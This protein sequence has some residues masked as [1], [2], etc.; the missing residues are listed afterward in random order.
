MSTAAKKPWARVA[1]R[2][3]EPPPAR[4]AREAHKPRP[5]RTV[6]APEASPRVRSTRPGTV[7]P[8][9]EILAPVFRAADW[10]AFGVTGLVMLAAYLW[11]LAPEVTL[12]D[13]GELAV[14]AQYA[15]VPHAPGYPIWTLYG[16]LFTKLLPFS[17]I[18]WRV[19]VSSAVA[20]ALACAWIALIV[21]RGSRLL[22]DSLPTVSDLV[23]A[24]RQHLG[25][26]S[27]CVAGALLGFSGFVWSQAVIVEVYTLSLLSLTALLACLFRWTCIPTQRR[28]LYLAWFLFGICLNNHQS[29]MVIALAMEVCVSMADRRLGRDL[30]LGN[31]LCYVIGLIAKAGGA[32]PFLNHNAP[33]LACYHAIGLASIGAA[34]WLTIRT[35]AL[36]RQFHLALACAGAFLVGAA[37][38]LWM[39]LGSMANPPMNWA[40]P[41]TVSGFFHAL[42]RG[43]YEPVHPAQDL[44]RYVE[45]LWHLGQGVIEEFHVFYLLAGLL[46]ILLL[47]RFAARERGWLIAGL[48]FYFVLGPGLLVLI[49]PGTERAQQELV[50][51]FFAA[52]HVPVAIAI[53]FGLALGLALLRTSYATVRQWALVGAGAAVVWGLASTAW[54]WHTTALALER[55]SALFALLLAGALLCLVWRGQQRAAQVALLAWVALMPL[56]SIL[57]HWRDNEQRGHWFGYWFGHDMFSPPFQGQAGRLEDGRAERAKALAAPDARGAYPEM[58]RNAVLFGGT[59]PGRFCP[60]YMIFSESFL[61]PGQRRDPEF[62]RRDVAIITQNALADVHYLE[63]IRAHY[64]RSAQVDPYFFSELLRSREE[65]ESNA[66]TNWLA[67]L[68]LPVDRA[69]TGVGAQVERQRRE[70]G[71]YP[72]EELHLPTNA[73]LDRCMNACLRDVQQRAQLG[74]LRPGEEVRIQDGR[75]ELSGPVLVMGVNALLTREIFEQNPEREFYV[76]ESFPLDWM[77]PHLTPFG[78]IMKIERQ[79]PA[80]LGAEMVERDH[81]FWRNYMERLAGDW[82]TPE[83]NATELCT[84]AERVH[85]RHDLRE[86]RGDQKFLRDEQAQKSF[87]KLRASIGG[88]YDWRFRHATGLLQ[89]VSRQLSETGLTPARAELLRAEQQRWSSEQTRM[90]REAEFALKQ[91]Y[92]LCPF[93]PEALQRLV[94]LLLA[95][96]RTADALALAEMS[97]KLDPG[98]VFFTN[99]AAQ[100][101]GLNAGG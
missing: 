75:A 58:T 43:Q 40:Y 14:A 24:W 20:G 61:E 47:R 7:P 92:A 84:F 68:A 51:V 32:L 56:G 52:S 35:R 73:D 90:Y 23:P 94:N 5:A 42:T 59:D 21:S 49:N 98:N 80:E 70:R 64:Q 81:A 3:A 63:Y 37:G 88:I 79:P 77:Y 82:V 26:L 1:H 96:G 62:D 93:N 41:R 48:A 99:V 66:A 18:G 36:G 27:G 101:R 2:A 55:Q 74:Q 71:V 13:S 22:L 25:V 30:F 16:W 15:G 31:S 87:S 8:R 67:R 12:E 33:L 78:I 100:L 72:K 95:G 6:S 65:R 45:Q 86:Y 54:T 60:T 85:L 11:T 69:L 9:P 38:Y 57:D 89:Q 10:L 44:G 39:P 83:T 34:L 50:R 28:Y 46:P 4:S 29:L 91:A 17:N 97:C 53:G 76:E 19:A